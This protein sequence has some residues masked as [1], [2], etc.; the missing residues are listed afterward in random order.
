M[1]EFKVKN[2]TKRGNKWYCHVEFLNTG[3]S[4]WVR[5]DAAKNGQVRDKT[6]KAKNGKVVDEGG[7]RYGR[8]FVKD[9][10]HFKNTHRDHLLHS[11]TACAIV[12]QK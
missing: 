3:Y 5:S 9:L 8:L 6:V 7:N 12:E 4:Y 1:G 10:S 2:K 11:G